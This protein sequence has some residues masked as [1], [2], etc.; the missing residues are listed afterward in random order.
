M[1]WIRTKLVALWARI[2]RLVRP[3]DGPGPWRPKE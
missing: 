1:N 3:A 2:K